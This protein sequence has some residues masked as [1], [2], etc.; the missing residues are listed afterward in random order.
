MTI[1]FSGLDPSQ[2]FLYMDDLKVIGCSE[3]HMLKN[4]P[5]VFEKCRKYN[6]KLSQPSYVPIFHDKSEF[7]THSNKV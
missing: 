2:A 5:D 6:L 4:L 1:A 3:K 7:Q